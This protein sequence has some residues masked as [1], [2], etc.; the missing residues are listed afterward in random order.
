MFETFWSDLLVA[1]IGAVLTV[2]IAFGTYRLQLRQRER[3]SVRH[4]ANQLAHRRAFVFANPVRVD[5]SNPEVKRDFDTC[6]GSVKSARDRVVES[7]RDV[8]PGSKVQEQL[9]AMGV[10]MNRFLSR[11]SRDPDGYC[12]LLNDLVAELASTTATLSKLTRQDLPLP[13]SRG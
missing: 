3:G 7:N 11:S 10:S 13:G 1:V 2:A 12:L 8:R 5:T 4:I 9:D 6:R